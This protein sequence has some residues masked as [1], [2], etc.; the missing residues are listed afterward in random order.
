MSLDTH[1]ELDRAIA[2]ALTALKHPETLARA[3]AEEA[4]VSE[5]LKTDASTVTRARA[6]LQVIRDNNAHERLGRFLP[7]G[8]AGSDAV[9]TAGASPASEVAGDSSRARTRD[10]PSATA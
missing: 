6:K 4:R 10:A 8:A 1:A 9:S 5:L 3:R 2:E 7:D